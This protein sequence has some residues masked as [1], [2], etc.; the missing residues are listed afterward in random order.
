MRRGQ[1][2][3]ESRRLKAES[4]GMA[5]AA[6]SHYQ[7]LSRLDEILGKDQ[8]AKKERARLRTLILQQEK[9]KKTTKKN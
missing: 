2:E 3:K 6:R 5:R 1:M 8:G 9:S 4:L 7:Q